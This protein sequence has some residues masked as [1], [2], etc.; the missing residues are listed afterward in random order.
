[1]PSL[2]VGYLSSLPIL[3]FGVGLSLF[4]SSSD[5][6]ERSLAPEA[7]SHRSELPAERSL[8]FP[9]SDDFDL[10][11]L[12]EPGPDSFFEGPHPPRNRPVSTPH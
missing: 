8:E 4:L 5:L 11:Y 6:L 10:R 12:S 1:M 9:P 3:L 2:R 7:P